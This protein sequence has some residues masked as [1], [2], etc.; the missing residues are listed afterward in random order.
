MLWRHP[1]LIHSHIFGGMSLA[2]FYY[3]KAPA[4][5]QKGWSFFAIES[6]WEIAT[7]I[8]LDL[9][10]HPRPWITND[11][12]RI[13][14]PNILVY[15]VLDSD[16]IPGD[17]SDPPIGEASKGGVYHMVH[18]HVVRFANRVRHVA[19]RGFDESDSIHLAC[20]ERFIVINTRK[21]KYLG[22]PTF[23]D[24]LLVIDL[25]DLRRDALSS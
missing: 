1:R 18:P 12:H 5:K 4:P 11:G 23:R 21:G 6:S 14:G 25:Q 16:S 13:L 7:L 17:E 19:L 3:Y 10:P 15:H 24:I 22:T 9:N 8:R 2:L 20:N